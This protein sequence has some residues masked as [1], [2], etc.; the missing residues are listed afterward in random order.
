MWISLGIR[1]CGREGKRSL[2]TEGKVV[3]QSP[4]ERAR[5]MAQW[6]KHLL[7]KPDA[8]A[9]PGTHGLKVTH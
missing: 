7:C 1:I 5:E 9:V 3:I 6:V 8:R 4:E 2:W